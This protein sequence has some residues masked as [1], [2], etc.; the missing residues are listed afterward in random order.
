MRGDPVELP[1]PF[2]GDG[3]IQTWFIPGAMQEKRHVTA[4]FGASK[5]RRKSADTWL[6]QSG[7]NKCNKTV[8]QVEKELRKQGTI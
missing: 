3:I 7:C 1:C 4:T 2:C 8:E 6:I 5:T